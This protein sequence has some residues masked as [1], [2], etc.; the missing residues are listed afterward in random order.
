M[1]KDS[2]RYLRTT[3]LSQAVFLFAKGQQVAGISPTDGDQKEFAFVKTDALEELIWL[4]KYG[5]RD[6]ER[7][8]VE[9]H[10]YEQARRE[11]LDRLKD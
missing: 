10:K 11:L 3:N 8:L 4:Y 7:L 1:K 2:N 5:E 9:V 6:D